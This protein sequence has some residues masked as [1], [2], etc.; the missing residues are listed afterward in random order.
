[1]SVQKMYCIS[2]MNLVQLRY[3]V[4][5]QPMTT[6]KPKTK[7]SRFEFFHEV[8]WPHH[9]QREYFCR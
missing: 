9:E 8:E 1:M 2:E 4:T 5:I 7:S 6:A 3:Y